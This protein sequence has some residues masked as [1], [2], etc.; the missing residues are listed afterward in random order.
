MFE[1]KLRGAQRNFTAFC[2]TSQRLSEISALEASDYIS[3][4]VELVIDL[5]HEA[6]GNELMCFV[7][8]NAA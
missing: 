5:F 6:E 7:T 4:S 1:V 2:E 3:L 8:R